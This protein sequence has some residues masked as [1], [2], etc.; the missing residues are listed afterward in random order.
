MEGLG[1]LPW[2]QVI[3]EFP[4][5][6]A[7]GIS[8]DGSVIVGYSTDSTGQFP[9]KAFRWTF[10]D[11]LTQLQNG[12]SVEYGDAE[13]SAISCDGTVIVGTRQSLSGGYS[14]FRWTQETGMVNLGLPAESHGFGPSA[15]SGDGSI[16]IGS[17]SGGFGFPPSG[18]LIWDEVNGF[19]N[20]Q[21]VLEA[22]YDLDLSGWTL[23]EA[24]GISADGRTIVGTGWH[25]YGRPE[26]WIATLP[27]GSTNYGEVPRKPQ[28]DPTGIEKTRFISFIP[29]QPCGVPT[30]IRVIMVSLHHVSP[31]YTGGASVPFS[32]FEGQVRW[33]GP[34]VTYF[35]TA[36]GTPFQTASLQCAPNYQD[37]STVGLIHVHGS[38]IVPSSVYEVQSVAAS[39]MGNEA[40]CSAVS[41]PLQIATTR[42][43]DV[44]EPYNP[45]SS[46]VQPDV[47]DVSALVNK[48]R[49]APGAPTKPRALLIGDDEF[50]NFTP[51]TLAVDLGFGHISA[52]LDAFRGK[53]YPH[54][55][56]TCP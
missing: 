37:W 12:D 49:S 54:T 11:G 41:A 23:F 44:E 4:I 51:A 21:D 17:R 34:P 26:G 43:G 25:P 28:V 1:F 5:S 46:T 29:T 30:A 15:V 9:T 38:A 7:T 48:F 50:G 3:G 33:V 42:W 32:A 16:V 56:A 18:A 14:S 6:G 24:T 27:L 31:P 39:C 45:P 40:G 55:I 13:P 10:V 8:C 53:P 22:E 47:G 36:G 19:C 2:N 35:P 20:L 52:C